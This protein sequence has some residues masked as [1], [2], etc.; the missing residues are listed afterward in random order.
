MQDQA[1]TNFEM[2]RETL[3]SLLAQ[4]RGQHALIHAGQIIGYFPTSISAIRKGYT[5]FG[6]GQFSVELVDDS[7]EDLGFFSHVSAALRA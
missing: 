4:H 3:P 5:E 6:E 1:S 2:F 7:P